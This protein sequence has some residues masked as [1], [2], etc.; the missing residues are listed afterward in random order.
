MCTQTLSQIGQM[1]IIK[2]DRVPTSNLLKQ[3]LITHTNRPVTVNVGVTSQ[4]G[5][6]DRCY[7]MY[8]LPCFAVDNNYGDDQGT[9]IQWPVKGHKIQQ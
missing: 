2:K 6:A 7:Q 5:Q 8:Y 4:D 9:S 3:P 1:T